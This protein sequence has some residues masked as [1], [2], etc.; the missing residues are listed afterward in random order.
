MTAYVDTDPCYSQ[1]KLA[2]VDAGLAD[3][4][5]RTSAALIRQHD[6]FFTLGEHVGQPGLP[7]PTA[8]LTWHPDAAA[9]RPAELAA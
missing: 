7:V 8:G 1:A 3:E 6:V 9:D 2:A 4:R 5:R